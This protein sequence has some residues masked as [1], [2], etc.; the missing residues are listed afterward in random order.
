M[1]VLAAIEAFTACLEAVPPK[2]TRKE[3][4]HSRWVRSRA[5]TGD[6]SREGASERAGPSRVGHRQWPSTPS[7]TLPDDGAEPR[8]RHLD[9]ASPGSPASPNGEPAVIAVASTPAGPRLH[10]RHR[11][12]HRHLLTQ[13][14]ERSDGPESFTMPAEG[15][16]RLVYGRLDAE[17]TPHECRRRRR[18]TPPNCAPSIPRSPRS[19]DPTPS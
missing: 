3:D 12:R 18:N 11:T 2:R 5:S 1:T 13:R 8:H 16:I 17:H 9:L 19:T 6:A 15:F 14:A 4:S 7:A 10:H